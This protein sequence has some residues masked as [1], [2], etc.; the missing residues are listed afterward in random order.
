MAYATVVIIDHY[1]WSFLTHASDTTGRMR[2]ALVAWQGS[3]VVP[4]WTTIA[5]DSANLVHIAYG[6]GDVDDL[7][8]RISYATNAHGAWALSGPLAD[9]IDWDSSPPSIG[10]DSSGKVYISYIDLDNR[11]LVISGEGKDLSPSWPGTPAEASAHGQTSK[12]GSS[13][14][15]NLAFLLVPIGAVI[16]LKVW[17]RRKQA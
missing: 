14:F 16:L 2:S 6:F 13:L 17:R 3:E 4:A 12:A 10:V 11:L 7:T 8:V 9:P 15:N 5:T 1:L